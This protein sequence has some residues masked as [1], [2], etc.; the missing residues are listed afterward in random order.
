MNS[1][2]YD[3]L[4]NIDDIAGGIELV[5][6]ALNLATEELETTIRLIGGDRYKNCLNVMFLCYERLF[7]EHA[8]LEKNSHELFEELKKEGNSNE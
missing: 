3:R 8:K 7:D 4:A 2:I 1:V 5:L 6:S